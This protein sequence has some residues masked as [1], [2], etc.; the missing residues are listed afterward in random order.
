MRQTLGFTAQG[1]WQSLGAR[2]L[3][4]EEEDPQDVEQIWVLHPETIP[5]GVEIVDKWM[6]VE[7]E[8]EAEE[9]NETAATT[10]VG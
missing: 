8:S 3:A 7:V 2:V 10:S 4:S 6:R 1:G 9:L 5:Q